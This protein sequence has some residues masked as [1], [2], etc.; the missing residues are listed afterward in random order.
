MK[1]EA[2]AKVIISLFL[3]HPHNILFIKSFSEKL[4]L[5]REEIKQKNFIFEK[6]AVRKNEW[7]F[8]RWFWS[9]LEHAV[10]H[11]T[12]YILVTKEDLLDYD[13]ALI[14]KSLKSFKV[15]IRE[16]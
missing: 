7:E 9:F 6:D 2:S 12:H 10:P 1:Y 8:K 13:V 16:V 3:K 4:K 15:E 11:H 14:V 5:F